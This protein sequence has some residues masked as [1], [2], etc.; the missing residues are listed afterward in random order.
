LNA[1]TSFKFEARSSGCCFSGFTCVENVAIDFHKQLKIIVKQ[2][3]TLR[4][5]IDRNRAGG[6]VFYPLLSMPVRHPMPPAALINSLMPTSIHLIPLALYTD[7]VF[8]Q[9]AGIKTHLGLRVTKFKAIPFTASS[10]SGS[11]STSKSRSRKACTALKGT[12]PDQATAKSRS[13][14]LSVPNKC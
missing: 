2:L 11:Q 13:A 5:G 3:R 14:K 10:S 6:I 8:G 9:L 7:D 12:L 4:A 1:R